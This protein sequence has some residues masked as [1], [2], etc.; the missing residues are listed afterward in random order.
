ME[1]GE[2]KMSVDRLEKPTDHLTDLLEFVFRIY[3]STGGRYPALE[4]VER[5]PHPEDFSAFSEVYLPFLRFR[6]EEEFDEIY[7]LKDDK[8]RIVGTVALVHNLAED[9]RVWWVPERLKRDG[10]GL[11][12]F[13]MVDPEYRGRGYG[14]RLLNMAIGRLREMRREIYVITFPHLEAYGYY[15]RRGF[16][17]VMDYREFVVLRFQG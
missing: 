9:K 15:L 4:W 10:V 14:E 11:I 8:G 2:P 1:I 6:L 12:E 3:R 5:K 7:V 13:F 16:V 17:K